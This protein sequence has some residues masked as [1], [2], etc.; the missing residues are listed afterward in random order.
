MAVTVEPEVAEQGHGYAVLLSMTQGLACL[1][2]T[3]RPLAILAVGSR[4]PHRAGAILNNGI[5][6]PG[7]LWIVGEAPFVPAL[8]I[9][10]S[11]DPE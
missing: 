6:R 2:L 3:N 9:T 1:H 4:E 11:P 8:E 10:A 7:G 5:D